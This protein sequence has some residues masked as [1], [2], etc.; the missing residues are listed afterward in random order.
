MAGR[1]RSM[2]YP[3]SPPQ[4]PRGLPAQQPRL[5]GEPT[6]IPQTRVSLVRVL[7]PLVLDLGGKEVRLKRRKPREAFI[8]L[9]LHR[10]KSLRMDYIVEALW[11]SGVPEHPREAVRSY[12]S[13][14]R[15]WIAAW[16]QGVSGPVLRS[17]AGAYGLDLHDS[18][19][20]LVQFTRLVTR[21]QLALREGLP[22]A[23]VR[24]LDEALGLFR[25]EP[26]QDA[27]D[28]TFAVPEITRLAE[29]RLE[30]REARALARLELGLDD[31]AI[32][33]LWDL[34]NEY[35]WRIRSAALL[36]VSLYRSRRQ[37][38]ALECAQAFRR[39]LWT[40]LGEWPD[41]SFLALEQAILNQDAELDRPALIR[42]AVVGGRAERSSTTA[43]SGNGR[44][45]QAFTAR[46][47]TQIDSGPLL[48]RAEAE[49]SLVS[50]LES[51]PIVSIVGPVGCGKSA[52]AARVATR[53]RDQM[54]THVVDVDVSTS[55]G[56]YE[57][58]ETVGRCLGDPA[59]LRPGD[60]IFLV[61]DN[62]DAF[63]E[64]VNQVIGQL[65]G[66][67]PPGFRVLCTSRRRGQAGGVVYRLDP[68]PC[69]PPAGSGPEALLASAAVTLFRRRAEATR[70]GFEPRPVQILA[71][72]R[73]CEAVDYLPLAIEMAAAQTLAVSPVELE[74]LLAADPFSVLRLPCGGSRPPSSLHAAFS[75]TYEQLT[76]LDRQMLRRLGKIDR[77]FT[78]GEAASVGGPAALAALSSLITHSIVTFG[79]SGGS[80][81]YRMLRTWR[82]FARR[83]ANHERA[84]VSQHSHDNDRHD[85]GTLDG[86]ADCS[87]AS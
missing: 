81:R 33:D 57:L 83:S 19:L 68:L 8:L 52:L 44:S 9:L 16:P 4:L 48:G 45:G 79:H 63:H 77:P 59:L 74:P 65:N 84:A 73:I 30:A 76:S 85:G 67:L 23:A 27:Y 70:R 12:L 6:G 18:H 24:D 60:G 66:H 47:S 75:R 25:G 41:P 46:H 31:S 56:A 50:M 17:E 2:S 54:G 55:S 82:A 10:G 22:A 71:V 78:L 32:T 1:L 38:E 15:S 80:V 26:F 34:A 21:G 7:G 72:A 40:E 37:V 69:T 20:D 13:S 61:L 49:E 42:T 5:S 39:A 11:G 3:S 36:M 35:P 28:C 62:C 87:P 64:Q 86:L 43:I 53:F 51:N 29:I 58:R 14:V